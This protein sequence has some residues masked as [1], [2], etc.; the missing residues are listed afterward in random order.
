[1]AGEDQ[2]DDDLGEL[3]RLQWKARDRDPALGA[4][5]RVADE[6]DRQQEQQA[7]AVGGQDE[8]LQPPIVDSGREGVGDP[9]QGQ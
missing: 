1:M 2:Q 4:E 7:G 9:G 6:V 8:A 5:R 3:R